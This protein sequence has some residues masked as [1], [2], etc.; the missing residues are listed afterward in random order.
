MF[1]DPSSLSLHYISIN[2]AHTSSLFIHLFSLQ[3]WCVCAA[4]KMWAMIFRRWRKR[5]WGWPW[6]RKWP[7]SNSSAPQTT[8]NQS[9]L[10]SSSSSLSS[11]PASTLWV[12]IISSNVMLGISLSSV[13]LKWEGNLQACHLTHD[14]FKGAFTEIVLMFLTSTR[15]EMLLG[16]R[17]S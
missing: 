4:V 10:L 8:V 14:I 15:Q 5:G 16:S 7:Y 2:N 11:C 12:N 17:Q 1:W 6:K 3:H 9:S 13:S